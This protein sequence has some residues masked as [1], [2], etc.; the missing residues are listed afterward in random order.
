MVLPHGGGSDF[1]FAYNLLMV[2]DIER[3]IL[4]VIYH[5]GQRFIES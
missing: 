3:A 1:N 2:E 5:K 4:Y